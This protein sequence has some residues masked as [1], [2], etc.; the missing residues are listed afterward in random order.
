MVKKHSSL[1]LLIFSLL[2]FLPACEHGQR[3]N[4]EDLE[5]KIND[6]ENEND[7]L[8]SRISDLEW[9]QRQY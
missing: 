1:G 8:E 6:L 2:L 3:E 5:W 9:K 4:I 7:N